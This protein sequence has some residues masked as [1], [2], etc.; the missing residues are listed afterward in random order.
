MDWFRELSA[1]SE[2]HFFRT[3]LVSF[4]VLIQKKFF[5]GV[6]KNLFIFKKKKT[7]KLGLQFYYKLEVLEFFEKSTFL[8][9]ISFH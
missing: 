7:R 6:P 8:P 2:Q 3:P 4:L 9:K 5:T 1:C